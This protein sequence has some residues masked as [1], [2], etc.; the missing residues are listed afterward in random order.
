MTATLPRP[1]AVR[2]RRSAVSAL[3]SRH[4]YAAVPLVLSV[5]LFVAN[6]AVRPSFVSVGNWAPA[7]AVL[8]PLVLTGMAL[9]L[10]VLS[11]NGGFDLSVGPVTGFVTVLVAGV[12]A[13]HGLASAVVV[14][15][16]VVLFGL[17]AGALNGL[18]VA[19]VQLPAIIATLGTYLLFT[20][21]GTEVLANPGGSVP[22]WLIDLNG[23]YGHVP[24]VLIVLAVVAVVWTLLSR[25]AFL[26]NLLAVGGDE[27]AAYTA[28]VPV[29]RVRIC[30]YAIGGVFA[31]IAGMMLTGLIQS[32]DG[33][34][35]P[36]YTISAITAVALGGLSLAGGRGGLL[37]AAL[38]G[39]V[40]FLAQN[41]L[42]ATHVSVYRVNVIDGALLILALAVNG[43]LDQ[44]RKRSRPA[45]VPGAE[46]AGGTELTGASRAGADILGDDHGR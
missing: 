28:G 32:G 8:C 44:L 15:P 30:A 1:A 40:L 17:G 26:R 36:P 18:L 27:R 42:T 13:P 41:L 23:S 34:V 6:V 33:T 46:T 9:A 24:G 4:S 45:A 2:G 38:G 39:L 7:L 11:G 3:I 10:P 16:L 35:G 12:L 20:G 37:G 19:Y 5:A 29:A 14:I 25:T 21:L 22:L 43:V 31:A